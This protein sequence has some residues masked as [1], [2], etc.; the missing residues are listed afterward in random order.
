MLPMVEVPAKSYEAYRDFL[1]G[2]A[3]NA[4]EWL[5]Q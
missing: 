1:R 3:P 4:D 2:V 5:E